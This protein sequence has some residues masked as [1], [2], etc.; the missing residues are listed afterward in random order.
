[1]EKKTK[2]IDTHN[3]GIFFFIFIPFG[4][5][6]I[7]TQI[8]VIVNYTSYADAK[9]NHHNNYEFVVDGVTYEGDNGLDEDFDYKE[10]TPMLVRYNPD[11]PSKNCI[12]SNG[13]TSQY[14]FIGLGLFT[15][16]AG[17]APYCFKVFK[18]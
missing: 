1:M 6:L 5:I 17:I 4:L 9:I 11:N 12:A 3:P 7:I 18:S 15:V 14:T 16:L 2:L 10:G 8:F 13:N